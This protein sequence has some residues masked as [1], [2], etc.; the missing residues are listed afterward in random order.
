MLGIENKFRA[1][2]FVIRYGC[3]LLGTLIE[4]S[5]HLKRPIGM[6][7]SYP[8]FSKTNMGNGAHSFN[9]NLLLDV[10]VFVAVEYDQKQSLGFFTSEEEGTIRAKRLRGGAEGKLI[11]VGENPFQDFR[12][13]DRYETNVGGRTT[14]WRDDINVQV[15]FI[16]G[17]NHRYKLKL[18][19]L[20]RKICPTGEIER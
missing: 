8:C 5:D 14:E 13:R 7:T 2:I 20:P 11:L 15:P 4:Q 10:L 1:I 18:F 16:L 19:M 9:E 12:A 3:I 6:N 17:A